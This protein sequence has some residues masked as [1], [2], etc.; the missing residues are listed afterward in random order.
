MLHILSAIGDNLEAAIQSVD[1]PL[2]EEP[3]ERV[4]DESCARYVPNGPPCF[5]Y[6]K[7]GAKPAPGW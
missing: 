5:C 6:A 3:T 7:A 4:C 1:S 2:E